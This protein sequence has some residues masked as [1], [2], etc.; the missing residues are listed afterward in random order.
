MRITVFLLALA[1]GVAA[2]PAP[3][4][5]NQKD[6][7]VEGPSNLFIFIAPPI[8]LNSSIDRGRDQ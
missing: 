4:I 1:L 8:L 6:P 7:L 2:L 3:S 5:N